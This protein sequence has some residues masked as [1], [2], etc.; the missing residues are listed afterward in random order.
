MWLI[1]TIRPLDRA[2]CWRGR[3]ARIGVRSELIGPQ[4][5]TRQLEAGG[6]YLRRQI[7]PLHNLSWLVLLINILIHQEWLSPTQIAVL[8]RAGEIDRLIETHIALFID[9]RR[10]QIQDRRT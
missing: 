8:A 3:V 5:H 7:N 4:G 9:V 1:K 10:A 6:D 2:C